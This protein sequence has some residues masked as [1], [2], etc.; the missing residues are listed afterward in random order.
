MRE[1]HRPRGNPLF[2]DLDADF[3]A[4]TAPDPAVDAAGDTNADPDSRSQGFGEA[5]ETWGA[6]DEGFARS[7]RSRRPPPT[8]SRESMLG[9]SASANPLVDALMEAGPETAEHLLRA[10]EEL[11][12]AAQTVVQAAERG[13]GEQRGSGEQRAASE[14][15]GTG[16][17]GPTTSDG[18]SPGGAAT[19]GFSSIHLD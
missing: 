16:A 17:E 5:G 14:R 10:M 9:R 3:G 13:V 8:S 2:D 7:R 4:D 6:S 11:L 1:T 12:L 18:E 19:G 15:R